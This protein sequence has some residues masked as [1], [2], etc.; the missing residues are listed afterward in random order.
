MF[1]QDVLHNAADQANGLLYIKPDRE[2]R[3]RLRRVLWWIAGRLAEDLPPAEFSQLATTRKC[4]VRDLS[5][6]TTG[7]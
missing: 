7:F 4:D 3:R 5:G 2:Q 1:F 6:Q